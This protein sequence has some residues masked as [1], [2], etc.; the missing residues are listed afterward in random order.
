MKFAASLMFA[1]SLIIPKTDK[2]SSARKSL[3]GAMIC[4]GLSVIPLIVVISITNGLINGMTERIINLASSHIQA[5]V[6]P[7][8][9]EVSSLESFTKYAQG[10][11]VVDGVVNAWP[12]INISAL[13]TGKTKRSGIEIRAVDQNIFSDNHWFK[14]L[15]SVVDGD[16]TLLGEG[17]KT[18]VIGKKMAE[19]LEL[20]AGDSFKIITTRNRNGKLTPKL[21]IFTVAAIVSSG[22]QE[23]DQ[24][25]VFIPLASAYKFMTL[26][27]ASFNVLIESEDPYSPELVRIQ[28]DIKSY[29]GRYANV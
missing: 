23:L 14:E 20:K 5:Y 24:F 13:A 1:K 2:K 11:K 17:G 25:W 27:D 15:F 8:I 28:R 18:A 26:K 16:P 29:F 22:Y 12:E 4:I 3:F 19:E 9:E 10:V 7:N 21:T 6:A